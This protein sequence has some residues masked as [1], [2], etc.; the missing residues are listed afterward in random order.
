MYKPRKGQTGQLKV[1]LE[2]NK[3]QLKFR[4]KPSE[5]QKGAK[6]NLDQSWIKSIYESAKSQI[7]V[8]KKT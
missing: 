1:K 2:S 3:I 7:Q 6:N 5:S 8:K 4:Y